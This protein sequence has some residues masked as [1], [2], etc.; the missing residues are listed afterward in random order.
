MKRDPHMAGS[1]ENEDPEILA[2]RARR[3]RL[4]PRLKRIAIRAGWTSIFAVGFAFACLVAGS[5]SGFMGCWFW[6]AALGLGG[7]A[8]IAALVDLLM[9]A[10][11]KV[12][13]EDDLLLPVGLGIPGIL[14]SILAIVLVVEKVSVL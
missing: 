11:L 2:E 12:L 1:D 8:P 14:V 9:V 7:V 3:E 6:G 10:W 13:G 4:I 5:L